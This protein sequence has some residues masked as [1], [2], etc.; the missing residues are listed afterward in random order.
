MATKPLVNKFTRLKKKVASILSDIAFIEECKREKVIP[1]FV[2][3]KCA[4]DNSRTEK[5]KRFACNMWM[6]L[7]IKHFYSILNDIQLE[8]YSLHLHIVSTLNKYEYEEWQNHC[9]KVGMM[10]ELEQERKREKHTRK[11][12]TLIKNQ[13]INKVTEPQYIEDFVCNESSEIFTEGELRIL[14]KGLNFT[15]RPTRDNFTETVIDIETAIKSKLNTVQCDIRQTAREVI[16]STSRAHMTH[17][18]EAEVLKSLKQRNCVYV[19][20]DKGNKLVIL[21]KNEYEDRMKQL[22]EDGPYKKISR[23][24]LPKMVKISTDMREKVS[25]V[26]G[27]R[28]K[29]IL[30]VSN[31]EVPK[32]YGLPKIHKP[33]KK[34]RPIVS[35]VNSPCYFLAK[36]LVKEMKNMPRIESASVKNSFDFVD[37]LKDVEIAEDEMM[38]SFDV[39]ALFPSIPIEHAIQAFDEYLVLNGVANEKKSVYIQVAKKCM[40]QNYFQ[41]RGSIYLIEHGTSMG[42]PLSPLIAELFMAMFET[43]LKNDG[44]LPRIWLRYV[45]DIFAIVR[46]SELNSLL[47]LLNE[48][49]ETINFTTEKEADRELPFL[50]LLVRNENG[51][52]KFAVYHKPTSTKRCISADSHCPIQHKKAAFHSYVHR[53]CKLPLSIADYKREYEH[54][55]EIAVLNGYNARM[56]DDL[57]VQHMRQIKNSNLTTLYTQNKRLEVIPKR[58]RFSYVP[59]LT[60]KLKTVFRRNNMEMVF[61]NNHK[62]KN[63]LGTTKD[64]TETLK[65]SGIYSVKCGDCD[66]VYYG[67]TKRSIETRFKEHNNY[68]KKNNCRPSALANHVLTNGHFNVC[69]ENLKLVRQVNDERRL[70]A[71]ES[72]HIQSDERSMNADNGNI[73]SCLFRLV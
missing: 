16:L 44:K 70:D 67:Q 34:M 59:K 53:L 22:I 23:N 21:D 71:Y 9:N 54:I 20:A 4:V 56:V 19:K 37:R 17:N 36:W 49:Y 14:N 29:R 33:G 13:R 15:P 65:K 30:L 43:T 40:E 7:E 66:E 52:I 2:S 48:Q 57:I 28:F 58:V 32:L 39:E 63:I 45:D 38:V 73:T 35:N 3:V 26:F 50:D 41:F 11:L 47:T 8:L 6:R 62:L 24:P 61:A 27:N 18:E 69:K 10:A 42:N 60:N 55:S 25:T 46:K 51:K 1:N 12:N 68:I 31:P 64:K 5:V 72:Y